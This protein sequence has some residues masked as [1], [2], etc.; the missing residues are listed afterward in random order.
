[1]IAR[2]LMRVVIVNRYAT[3]SGG[4]EKHAVGLATRLRS[5]GHDVRFLSTL[6]DDNVEREGAFIPLTGTDFWRGLPPLRQRAEVAMGALWSRRAAAAMKLLIARSRPDVVHLHDIY[7]QLSVAPA[8]VAASAGIPVVQTL[9]NYELISASATDDR[10][11]WIDRSDAALS[12]RAL[13]TALHIARKLLHVP[14]VTLWIAVSRYVAQA[15][16]RHGIGAEVLPNFIETTS[17][18]AGRSFEERTGIVFVGRLTED[19]GIDD[20][21]VLA[22]R[23][24]EIPVTI[25]GRGP[26]EGY[27]RAQCRALRNLTYAGFLRRR[28]VVERLASS[29]ILVVPSR[30]QEPAGLVALEGMAEGTPVIAYASGG[31]GEYVRDARAGPVVSADE[32]ALAAAS[33]ELYSDREAWRAFSSHGRAAIEGAHSPDRYIRRLETLYQTAGGGT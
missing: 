17:D 15:Y 6:S 1:M 32:E 7:P 19:K 25:I 14:R 13:R 11:G 27:V 24:P 10:G 33:R 16:A 12:V 31:L 28:E 3:A 26:L 30:W 9:H 22:R 29:R 18:S 8:V 5:R 21:T 23:L 20:V 4:A 2:E